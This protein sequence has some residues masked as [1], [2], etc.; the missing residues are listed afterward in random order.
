MLFQQQKLLLLIPQKGREMKTPSR[1][2]SYEVEG[3]RKSFC[4]AFTH[5][6][7]RHLCNPSCMGPDGRDTIGATNNGCISHAGTP[8]CAQLTA[9]Q[10]ITCT[11]SLEKPSGQQYITNDKLSLN[12]SATHSKSSSHPSP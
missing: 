1:A 4:T 10:D 2:Q 12:P 7:D 8:W 11:S 6:S 3:G 9:P 5:H